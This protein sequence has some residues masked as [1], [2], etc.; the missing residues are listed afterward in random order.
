MTFPLDVLRAGAAEAAPR[1]LGAVLETRVD[2]EL[3]RGRIVETEAYLAEGD[4]ASHSASGPTERN[5]AMFGPAGRAYVYLIY[6]MHLCFNVVTGEA[7]RG[8]AVLVRAVEPLDG[9]EVMRRRRGE[10]SSE[11]DLARGPGR[12]TQALAIAREHDRAPLLGRRAAVRLL[13]RPGGDAPE[14]IVVG[15]RVGITRDTDLPLRFRV[16]GSRWTS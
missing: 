16:D 9:I 2:G 12:L 15:P 3:T 6:G 14:S 10:R 4:G 5:R 7:G 1:L 11:R 13:D 8:E